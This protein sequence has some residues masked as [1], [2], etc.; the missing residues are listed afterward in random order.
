M[1]EMEYKVVRRLEGQKRLAKLIQAHY[2]DAL[3]IEKNKSQ[4]IAWVS[5]GAPTEILWAMDFCVQFPEAYAATCGARHVA[6]THVEITEA[7]GYE[8]HLCT[9]CRNSLGAA[10]AQQE[11]LETFEPLA[12]PDF[13]LVSNGS[14]ILVTKWWEHL[15]HLWNIPLFNIDCPLVIP[16]IDERQLVDHVKRQCL[17]LITFLENFTGKKFDYDRLQ[18][19]VANGKRSS[20]NYLAMLEANKHDPVPATFFDIMGHNFPNLALRYKP[21]VA[22][23]YRLMKE[24]LDQRIADGIVPMSNIKY[25][26]YWDGIPYWFAIRELSEKLES[27]GLCLVT[28]GY[29]N[30][31]SFDRLD[32]ARPLDSVAEGVATMILNHNVSYKAE[33]TEKIFRDYNLEGG[34][35]AY[36]QSCKP[37]SITMRYIAEHVQ[38]KLNVPVTIIEGDLVDETFYDGERNNMKLQALAETL[39]ARRG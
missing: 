1:A 4:P 25:R 27:L 2:S 16:E 8:H 38:N 19:I 3:E 17:D 12:R 31:F 35:F 20:E 32:P 33:I 29:F 37:F 30:L 22:E 26:I 10:I 14:C 13:L 28:S 18:E 23:H 5:A 7:H 36:A 34:I 24:E 11:G 21:E 9:Y 39:A 6:H 15:S